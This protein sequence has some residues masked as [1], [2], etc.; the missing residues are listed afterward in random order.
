ML[1]GLPED[2]QS[3]IE[4]GWS[5]YFFI[6]KKQKKNPIVGEKIN[7]AQITHFTVFEKK[8]ICVP[9][10]SYVSL[11]DERCEIAMYPKIS[12]G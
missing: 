4:L 3:R 9:Y 6:T 2:E 8:K 7:V 10:I 1:G 11:K 12:V 5:F